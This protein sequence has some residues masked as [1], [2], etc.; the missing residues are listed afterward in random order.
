MGADLVGKTEAHI[1]EDDYVRNTY[2][3]GKYAACGENYGE[4]HKTVQEVR[5]VACK[6]RSMY[7]TS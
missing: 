2:N 4:Q 6:S 5:I 3:A 1:P 7:K